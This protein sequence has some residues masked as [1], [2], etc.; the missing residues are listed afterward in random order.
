[1]R[2]DLRRDKSLLENMLKSCRTLDHDENKLEK[3]TGKRFPVSHNYSDFLSTTGSDS[4]ACV[5]L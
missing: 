4:F 2:Q 5:E 3:F 1:M